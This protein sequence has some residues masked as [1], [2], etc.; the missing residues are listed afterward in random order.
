MKIPPKDRIKLY[1]TGQPSAAV[2]VSSTAL[3]RVS[4]FH[5]ANDL[6]ALDFPVAVVGPHRIMP[7]IEIDPNAERQRLE[8]EISRLEGEIGK[9]KAKLANASFVERAPAKVVEQERA[10]LAGFEATLAKLRPQLEKLTA[11]A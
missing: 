7:T 9:A 1:V 11:R 3:L 5:S 10:R 4:E 2:T 6:P 8:K